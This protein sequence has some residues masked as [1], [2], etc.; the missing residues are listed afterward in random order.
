MIDPL[1]AYFREHPS[2]IQLW[3]AGRSQTLSELSHAFDES[4]AERLPSL[5]TW[6]EAPA[7]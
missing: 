5:P 4:W 2:F 3:F 7:P 1:L 6:V